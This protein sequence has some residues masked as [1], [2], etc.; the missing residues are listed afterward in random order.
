MLPCVFEAQEERTRAKAEQKKKMEEA[1]VGVS[2]V[3]KLKFYTHTHT[4]QRLREQQAAIPPQEMFLSQTD[5][6]SAFDERGLSLSK[7]M[8]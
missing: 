6:Y 1:R 5:K 4:L 3:W 7:R 2:L 8:L